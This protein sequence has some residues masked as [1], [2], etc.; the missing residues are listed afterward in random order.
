MI[1]KHQHIVDRLK[2]LRLALEKEEVDA[3]LGISRG[4]L[5]PAVM[6]SHL[7]GLPL[8]VLNF[9]TRDHKTIGETTID[10]SKKYLIVDDI[11]D[12]GKTMKELSKIV[13]G[14]KLVVINCPNRHHVHI[15]YSLFYV[16]ETDVWFEFPW[17]IQ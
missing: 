8:A 13:N 6:V 15:D 9:S 2:Q 14:P 7:L 3:V 16:Y 4:G 12:S 11:C 5:V 17:E 1:V 10:Y